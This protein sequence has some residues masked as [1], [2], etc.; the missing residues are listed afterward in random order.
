M[1]NTDIEP[2]YSKRNQRERH[3]A[4]LLGYLYYALVGEA[5][6]II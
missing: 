3:T 2:G 5:L 1:L 4:C 6:Q